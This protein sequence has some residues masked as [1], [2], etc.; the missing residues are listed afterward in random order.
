MLN[1]TILAAGRGTRLGMPDPKPLTHLGD[2]R[3]IMQQQM[4]N[5]NTAFGSD[6]RPILVVGFRFYRVVESFPDTLFVY[7]EEFES[8]NT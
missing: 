6:F 2:G 4:Q 3:T 7:N 8:T 5:L 1:V